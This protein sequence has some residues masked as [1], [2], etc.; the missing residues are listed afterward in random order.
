MTQS[1]WIQKSFQWGK[2]SNDF[3]SLHKWKWQAPLITVNICLLSA[4]RPSVVPRVYVWLQ[5]WIC[6][7]L[8][9]GNQ[10]V[11][12]PVQWSHQRLLKHHNV[13]SLW[14]ETG[15]RTQ[16]KRL[17]IPLIDS[18]LD[19]TNCLWICV[20]RKSNLNRELM[21]FYFCHFKSFVWFVYLKTLV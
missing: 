11:R 5:N 7:C 21:P 1:L 19:N 18:A 14:R 3:L 8:R 17:D 15:C 12:Q 20:Y 6:S 10:S 9:D 16:L 2:P 4:N 13:T